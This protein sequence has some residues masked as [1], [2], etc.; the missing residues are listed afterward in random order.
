MT[1]EINV[2]GSPGRDNALWL[3][4]DSGQRVSR[5]LFDCGYGCVDELTP[6]EVARTDGLFFS[7]FHMDH[8]GGFD[9]FFRCNFNRPEGVVSVWGPPGTTEILHHRFRGYWWNLIDGSPG[10][11]IVRDVHDNE[12][13]AS[14]FV[15]SDG[16]ERREPLPDERA[17]GP[18]VAND[19]YTIEAIRLDHGGPSL[20]YVV[21][22]CERVNVD[23]GRLKDLGLRPG[24]WLQA[25]K[26]EAGDDAIEIDGVTQSLSKLREA[27]LVVTPGQSVAYLTDFKLDEKEQ[28]R[29]AEWLSPCGTLVCE[30]QYRH[31]DVALAEKNHHT[32]VL[33]VA[34]L[35]A[36]AGVDRLVL[37]HL[38]DRYSPEEWK[39]MLVEAREGF[40]AT[41]FPPEWGMD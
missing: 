10:E 8:V 35:A 13:T 28:A 6:G 4:V 1:I 34:A 11:W 3:K 16:F 17:D 33:L 20:G 25:L 31:E 38:S 21:R 24:P 41:S 9:S 19:D 27:L 29:L 2:L 15:A 26:S 37:Q 7:H 30:A 14:R 23:T 32:T 36:A 40:P 18:L 39:A 22:E 5:L 12:V